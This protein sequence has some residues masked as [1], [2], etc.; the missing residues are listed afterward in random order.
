MNQSKKRDNNLNVTQAFRLGVTSTRHP[1]A[2]QCRP[3]SYQV[4][5]TGEWTKDLNV[6][7]MEWYFL[8]NAVDDRGR[9][10]RSCRQRM[11]D[12]WKEISL[13]EL[14]EQN[15]SDQA[16]TIILEKIVAF[17]T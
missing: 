10:K 6:A 14:S 13:F 15:H 7:V 17:N 1:A 5:A 4:T 2:E 9:P 11:D 12:I 16:R 8:S 3:V